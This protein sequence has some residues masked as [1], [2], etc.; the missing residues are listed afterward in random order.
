M[1]RFLVAVLGVLVA[2]AGIIPTAA[3]AQMMCGERTKVIAGLAQGYSETPTSMGLTSNGAV[4]EVLS[5][6]SGTFTIIVTQPSGLT[7]LMASGEDWEELPE[8]E[9]A[10][11]DRI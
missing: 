4:V 5:S 6:P 10:T 9:T 1:V 3:Q 2:V 8:I 7:C 11:G